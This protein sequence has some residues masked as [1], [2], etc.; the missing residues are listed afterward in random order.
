MSINFRSLASAVRTSLRV[1][2]GFWSGTSR[3]PGT[4]EKGG[5]RAGTKVPQRPAPQQR[6]PG[7]SSRPSARTDPAAYP[8]DFTGVATVR[9]AP[10]PDGE[11]DP[12]EVVWTWVP[13]EEDPALGKDRPV[14]V[15]GHNGPYLLGLMLTSKDH[16]QDRNGRSD[17]VDIGTGGW[18]RQ[19]RPSE[20]KLGRI[21]QV[22]PDNIRREGAVL[23]RAHFDL[24]AEGLRRRHGWK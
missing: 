9:Y 1:L 15:I 7:A 16:N 12:G 23:D 13:Y 2:Q 24:V 6:A 14:L 5:A 20:A 8:G 19:L 4:A 18:D 17:Y 10:Q 3:S 21:L 11:P 22:N